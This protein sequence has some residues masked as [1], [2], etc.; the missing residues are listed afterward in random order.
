MRGDGEEGRERGITWRMLF[1][2][3]LLVIC[4]MLSPGTSTA[5]V[6]ARLRTPKGLERGLTVPIMSVGIASACSTTSIPR[7]TSPIASTLVFPFSLLV[8]VIEKRPS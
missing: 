3:M 8:S 5:R 2:S 4:S 7:V 1:V 6:S